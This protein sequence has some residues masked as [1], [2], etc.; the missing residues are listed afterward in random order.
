MQNK[1]LTMTDKA[2]IRI[3]TKS[4]TQYNKPFDLL[5]QQKRINIWAKTS[6]KDR[7]LILKYK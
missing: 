1:K 3:H 2:M 6:N 4:I 7:K 5:P